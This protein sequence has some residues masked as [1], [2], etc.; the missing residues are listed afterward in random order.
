LEPAPGQTLADAVSVAARGLD[1]TEPLEFLRYLSD[2]DVFLR[3]R[4]MFVV[5][6]L[7]DG[8]PTELLTTIRARRACS[9]TG[10]CPSCGACVALAT[11][12]VPHEYRCPVSD[13]RLVPVLSRW[14]RRVGLVRGRR[15]QEVPGDG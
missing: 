10:R 8:M 13:D 7:W 6:G 5:P 11:G 15:I 1:A 4:V 12:T 9:V 3:S 2:D 14:Y